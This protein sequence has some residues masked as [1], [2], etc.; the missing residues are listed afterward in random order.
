MGRRDSRLGVTCV[1]NNPPDGKVP[2]F[3]GRRLFKA[4]DVAVV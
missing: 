4:P 1:A 3:N 2:G